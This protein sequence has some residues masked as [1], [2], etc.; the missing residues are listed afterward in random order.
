M[1]LA[2]GTSLGSCVRDSPTEDLGCFFPLCLFINSS[3]DRL[4]DHVQKEHNKN[5]KLSIDVFPFP[6]N[7]N[8]SSES[9][10]TKCDDSA[11]LASDEE[12]TSNVAGSSNLGP[13][14]GRP[15]HLQVRT[16]PYERTGDSSSR[17]PS[18]SRM[19]LLKTHSPYAQPVPSPLNQLAYSRPSSPA[20]P[21]SDDEMVIY[22]PS[23]DIDETA[24]NEEEVLTKGSFSIITLS[25]LQTTPPTR[26]LACTRCLHGVNSSSLI[27]H[28][29]GHGIKLLPA[30]RQNLQKIIDNSSFL[31]DTNYDISSPIPPCPP[32]EGLLVQDGIACNLCSYCTIGTRTMQNHFSAKHKGVLGFSKDNT[33]RAQVQSLFPR[34]PNHFAVT[35]IL[36]GLNE[37]DL[38]TV[39]LQQCAPEIEN[40]RILNPPLNP[41]E[42]PPLL[43]IMQWHEHLKDYITDRDSVRKLLELTRLPTSKQG[44]AWMGTPLRDTIEGYMRHVAGLANNSSLGIRCLLKECPRYIVLLMLGF[45][46]NQ[47]Y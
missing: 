32:I 3:L 24:F 34:R 47:I 19:T 5:K 13:I 8:S 4:Q 27:S 42:V 40:L 6:S 39:Y 30:E 25:H 44:E 22:N 35:P 37:D 2:S 18:S 45:N 15:P 46:V 41:N 21:T 29:N 38:F 31:D 14:R 7:Q 33:K 26:L 10:F 1:V 28:S 23:L 20:P 16:T 17:S 11:N 43:K 36:R 9:E 12:P